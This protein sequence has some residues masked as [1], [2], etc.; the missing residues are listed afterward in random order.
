MSNLSKEE[1]ELLESLENGEWQSIE[2]KDLELKRYQKLAQKQFA[3]PI[4][5]DSITAECLSKD[6]PSSSRNAEAT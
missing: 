1:S 2:N 4:Y 3:D 6:K 5:I